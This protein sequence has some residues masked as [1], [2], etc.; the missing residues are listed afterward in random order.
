V[1]KNVLVLIKYDKNTPVNRFLFFAVN[2]LI[3]CLN[4]LYANERLL[5]CSLERHLEFEFIAQFYAI[6]SNHR[7]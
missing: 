7:N 2:Q 4:L 5:D 1:S 3:D 6:L